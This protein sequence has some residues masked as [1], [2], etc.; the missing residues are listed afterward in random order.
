MANNVVLTVAQVV[1]DEISMGFGS[2]LRFQSDNLDYFVITGIEP[3][4]YD[5]SKDVYK[6]LIYFKGDSTGHP[7]SIAQKAFHKVKVQRAGGDVSRFSEYIRDEHAG[8]FDIGFFKD[9]VE[10]FTKFSITGT[11]DRTD[12]SGRIS[13]MPE[14]Y[15][16]YADIVQTT[17]KVPG[18]EGFPWS[19]LKASGG[20]SDATPIQ[21]AVVSITA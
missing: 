9:G 19:R 13:Y 10:K 12:T 6:A 18:D 3:S 17:N 1:K 8:A 15:I 11:V 5:E 21:D 2:M 7:I 20:K 14:D 16:G 4:D